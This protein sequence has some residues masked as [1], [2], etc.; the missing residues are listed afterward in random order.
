MN[1]RL[2]LAAALLLTGAPALRAADGPISFNGSN[3]SILVPG[4][5]GAGVTDEVTVE[6]WARANGLAQQSAFMLDPDQGANRFQAHISYNS[7]GNTNTYWDFGNIGTGGR[8]AVANPP[9]TVGHWT[10]YALVSSASGGFLKIYV[11]GAEVATKASPVSAF[12]PAGNSPTGYGL[13]HRR[14]HRL[15]F[16]RQDRRVPRLER[17]PHQGADPDQPRHHPHRH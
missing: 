16:R 10:H 4:F 8:L 2:F 5:H 12:N 17:G 15:P 9:D 7:G 11:N 1:T 14:R 3:Q 13:E 6:F